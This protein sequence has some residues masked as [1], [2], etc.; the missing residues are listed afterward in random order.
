MPSITKPSA[1][2]YMTLPKKVRITEETYI[3]MLEYLDWNPSLDGENDIDFLIE[4]SIKIALESDKDF[5][6]R[7]KVKKA[8]VVKEGVTA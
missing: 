2:S 8:A 1:P 4:E 7:N 6:R 3:K 5:K